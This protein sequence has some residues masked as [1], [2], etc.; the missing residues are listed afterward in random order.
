LEFTVNS[1][2]IRT[3]KL[4]PIPFI[5]T[6][7][8]AL[9]KKYSL[10][11]KYLKVFNKLN[12]TYFASL[13]KTAQGQILTGQNTRSTFIEKTH[14]FGELHVVVLVTGMGWS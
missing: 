3:S 4:K 10:A 6:P 1:F 14:V 8:C 13:I 7:D 5:R 2:I 12:T 11:L 9:L